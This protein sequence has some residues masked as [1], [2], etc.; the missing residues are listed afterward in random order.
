[1]KFMSALRCAL[2]AVLILVGALSN[3]VLA[4]DT[5]DEYADLYWNNTNTLQNVIWVMNQTN[6]NTN[7]VLQITN[8]VHPWHMVAV[9]DFDR[10][11]FS[12][13][14]WRDETTGNNAIWLMTNGTMLKT[15]QIITMGDTNW[16][17][18]GAYDAN[19]DGSNDIWWRHKTEDMNAIWY[20]NLTNFITAESF[21]GSPGSFWKA[22]VI[23]DCNNDGYGDLIWRETTNS[24]G[25]AIWFM[26][27]TNSFDRVLVTNA[28]AG[29]QTFKLIGAG[30]LNRLGNTDFLWQ[31][32]GSNNFGWLMASNQFIT[33]TTNIHSNTNADWQFGG[34]GGYNDGVWHQMLLMAIPD[35][36]SSKIVLNWRYGVEKP[37]IYRRNPGTTDWGGPLITNLSARRFTNSVTVGQRYEYLVGGRYLLSAINAPPTHSR[38][39]VILVVDQTVTNAIEPD[40]SVLT[41]NLVGDGWTVI[42]TNVPRHNDTTWSANTGAIASIKSFIVN[43]YNADVNTKAI[44]LIGHVPIPYS[45]YTESDIHPDHHGAWTADGYY[46][47]TNATTASGN[48]G[49]E[50]T[51]KDADYTNTSYPEATNLTGDGKWDNDFFPTNSA[52][53]NLQMAVGRVDFAK[54]TDF[55]MPTNGAPIVYETN[56]LSRYLQKNNKYRNKQFASTN[57]CMA[58]GYFGVQERDMFS[59]SNIVENGS[60]WFGAN[61]GINV[62]GDFF[63][64]P[65]PF[66]AGA[67]SGFGNFF[68][69]LG[70]SSHQT[71]HLTLAQNEPKGI[72][73]MIYGSYFSDFN[74][75]TNNIYRS[76]LAT[77]NY[78]LAA[79][80]NSNSTNRV[81]WKFEQ[82]GLGEPLGAGMIRTMTNAATKADRW[83]TMMGDPT[84]RIQI[85]APPSNLNGN[86]GTTVTLNWTAPPPS[87][88]SV[89]YYVYLSTNNLGGPF[90]LLTTNALS[91]T[92]YTHNPAPSGAKTYM[93]RAAKLLTTGTGS[94]TNLSQGIFLNVN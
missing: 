62:N 52:G 16:S 72:F 29:D 22:S 2:V 9:A 57:R 58:A 17:V 45:G 23:G 4:F 88:G 50:W 79:V 55:W 48:P 67:L 69:I 66:F 24:G 31:Q 93:V 7:I 76:L 33:A 70:A 60:R 59:Y 18:I 71:V 5:L 37:D 6:Y 65:N 46:G 42:R 27:G 28:T 63:I 91:N 94:F 87:E 80:A 14:L 35:S 78:G 61:A 19:N 32:Y 49:I 1:M 77:A 74:L 86:S 90:P 38:G 43:Q 41:T 26:R 81:P 92:T 89:Q 13:L 21:I 25:V 30:Q 8:N 83:I 56:L 11:G 20:M 39:K 64:E 75:A 68:A 54:L 85:L 44:L 36:A 10:D 82:P 15:A 84:L 3:R 34:I 47:S 51:D 12:D 40:L 53:I 73:Y